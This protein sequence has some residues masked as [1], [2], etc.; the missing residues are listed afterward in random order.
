MQPGC[1]ATAL[2]LH[3]QHLL[4]RVCLQDLL[5]RLLRISCITGCAHAGAT[6]VCLC[7][8]DDHRHA[9]ALS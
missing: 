1:A 8:A 7:D 5:L 6:G 2:T 9:F 3:P 4:L